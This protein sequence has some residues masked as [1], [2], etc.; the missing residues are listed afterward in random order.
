V[1][2]HALDE[3]IA[4]ALCSNAKA[5]EQDPKRASKRLH[6]T[7]HGLLVFCIALYA[8]FAYLFLD[9]L[10]IRYSRGFVRRIGLER[11]GFF[12]AACRRSCKVLRR[13]CL[14]RILP[15]IYQ[16]KVLQIPSPKSPAAMF[17]C[18][19]KSSSASL[20]TSLIDFACTSRW[21][22]WQGRCLISVVATCRLAVFVLG[23]VTQASLILMPTLVDVVFR[24]IVGIAF[25][26]RVL[27]VHVC[28]GAVNR[29][30]KIVF[31]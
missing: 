18:G 12:W 19:R 15:C 8:V 20:Q 17:E 2:I 31:Y 25:V 28:S 22:R 23:S 11:C 3:Q 16:V 30:T 13:C 24:F 10:Q 21:R 29:D 9:A 26:S 5:S 14:C 7:S 6:L 4:I 27:W 1:H